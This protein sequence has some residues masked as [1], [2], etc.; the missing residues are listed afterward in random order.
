[1]PLDENREGDPLDEAACA[2][3]AALADGEDVDANALKEALADPAVRDYLVDLVALRQ[4]VG[5]LNEQSPLRWRERGSFSSR[6]AWL[7]VAAALISLT[8]GY[9]V[10]QRS[11]EAAPAP[12]VE[13]VVHLE[14]AEPAPRPTR[15]ISLRPGVNWT[16]KA[17]AQ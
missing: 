15:V 12:A 9:V 1:M 2:V 4:A 17:G 13:T 6:V 10:G 3:V 7:S 16:E 14:G 11:V 8:A 5:R